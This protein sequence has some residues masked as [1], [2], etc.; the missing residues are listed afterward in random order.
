MIE[1]AHGF[2]PK[3]WD[4]SEISVVTFHRTKIQGGRRNR[5]GVE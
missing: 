5:I 4:P 1:L 2:A 3:A